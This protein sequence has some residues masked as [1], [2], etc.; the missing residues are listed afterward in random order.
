MLHCKS[1]DGFAWQP[2]IG[3]CIA[4]LAM[5]LCFFRHPAGKVML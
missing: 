1:R 4:A 5:G 2:R 3:L